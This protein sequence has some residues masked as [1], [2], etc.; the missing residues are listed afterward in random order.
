M[1]F[2]S[3]KPAIISNHRAAFVGG[4]DV[5]N[6]EKG[7]KA[8]DRLFSEILKRW[9]DAEFVSARDLGELIRLK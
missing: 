3:K 7:L 6:R 8:L 2:D 5:A 4:I 9:P 1:A